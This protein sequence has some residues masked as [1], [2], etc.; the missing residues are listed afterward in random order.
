VTPAAVFHFGYPPIMRRMVEQDGAELALVFSQAKATG[1]TTSLDMAFPD[2]ASAAG[3]AD[4][5]RILRAT[6]PNVDVFMPSVEEILFMLR[7]AT[8]AQLQAAAQGDKGTSGDAL[9]EHV[10]PELLSD[11]SGELLDLGAKIVGL[12]LGERGLYL[13]TA[14]A[15]RLETGG[16]ALA[17]AAGWADRELWAPCFLVDVAGTTGSGDATIAGFLSALLRGY[18]PT[19]AVT[20]AVAVGACNVEA[21]DALSGLRS[22]EATL[23]RVA[24]GWPRRPLGGQAPG[25]HWEPDPGVWVGPNDTSGP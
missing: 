6:L 3:R 4:W 25:W 24:G 1:V 8:F 10:T 21:A 18:S 12:K 7:R 5:P 22:W 16:R 19:A 15:G 13:R 14:S 20:S 23:A 9:V 2:P 17:N 11:L